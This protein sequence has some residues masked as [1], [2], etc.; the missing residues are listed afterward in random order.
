ML[1]LQYSWPC[2]A[3]LSPEETLILGKRLEVVGDGTRRPAVRLTLHGIEV[4]A[5]LDTGGSCSLLRLNVFKKLSELCHR[6]KLLKPAPPLCSVTGSSLDVKG[7]TEV[8]IDKAGIAVKVTIVGDMS[9]EMIIG[10]DILRKGKALIDLPNNT[11]TWF[12]KNWQLKSNPSISL[13]E[14]VPLLPESSCP[15][16]NNILKLNYDIFSAKGQPNGY[17]DLLPM[18]IDTSCPPICLPAYRTTPE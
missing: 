18:S 16:I 10:A 1:R 7:S 14:V 9:H 2:K 17:C 4:T 13:E 5:L 8:N 11:L 15:E 6:N 3:R 12:N